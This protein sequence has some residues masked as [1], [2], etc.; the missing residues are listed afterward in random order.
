MLMGM[1]LTVIN[2]GQT[3]AQSQFE[4]SYNGEPKFFHKAEQAA[5][6]FYE[7]CPTFLSKYKEDLDSVII[8]FEELKINGFCL[9]YQCR[10][11]GWN[12]MV[13]LTTK[14]NDNPKFINEYAGH[15]LNFKLGGGDKPGASTSKFPEICG[16]SKISGSDVHWDIPKLQQVLN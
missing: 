14:V 8:T 4:T 6:I 2:L 16:V 1:A 5:L 11:Y 9:S 10:E 12:E 15:T 3:H 13:T 7:N